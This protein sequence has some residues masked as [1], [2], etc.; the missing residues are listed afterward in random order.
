MH[1]QARKQQRAST[2]AKQKALLQQMQGER[3]DSSTKV[4]RLE[5][6][7][8]ELQ[9]MLNYAHAAARAANKENAAAVSELE[10]DLQ[11]AKEGRIWS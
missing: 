9:R 3:D 8:K 2:S 4:T 5:R 1:E 11:R 6:E 10:A 7:I